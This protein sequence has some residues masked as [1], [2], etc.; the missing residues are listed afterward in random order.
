MCIKTFYEFILTKI[1]ILPAN[2][3]SINFKGEEEEYD[4]DSQFNRH[5]GEKKSV[6]NSHKESKDDK[7]H[8]DGDLEKGILY[9]I[10]IYE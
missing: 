8:N 1:L 4:F 2:H 10:S 7:Y 3:N 6:S 5:S 9:K